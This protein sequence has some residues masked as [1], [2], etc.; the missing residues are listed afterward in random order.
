MYSWGNGEEGQLG[1]GNTWNQ[2]APKEI[3]FFKT[4]SKEKII[5][6]SAGWYH[7]LALTSTFF[8]L[9]TQRKLLTIFCIPKLVIFVNTF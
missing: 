3:Q 5:D 2:L 9:S 6:I 8:L 4:L 7:S 1:H